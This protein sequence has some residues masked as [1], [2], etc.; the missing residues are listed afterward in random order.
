MTRFI[1]SIRPLAGLAALLLV[2]GAA[3]ASPLNVDTGKTL[4]L[5][6]GG[7][8]ILTLSLTNE[9]AGSAITNFNSWGFGLQLLPL[10]GATGTATLESA[11]LPATN[12]A[13]TNPEDPPLFSAETL[14]VPANGTLNYTLVSNGNLTN[15]QTTFALGQQYNVADVTVS[16]SP[17][18]SGSWN[19]YAVNNENGIA[20]WLAAN[21]NATD[22]GNLPAV[23]GDGGTLLIGTVS[24]VP[25]PG[26]IVLSGS[27]MAAAGWFAWRSRRKSELVAAA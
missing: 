27:A 25:E 13:L 12:P 24:A 5:Q 14:D 20:A 4:V 26:G 9:N 16:L 17:N 22:F 15:V 8:G 6:P 1:G 19:L 10:A 11:A 3:T 23:N 7:S 18:A 21:G 2:A